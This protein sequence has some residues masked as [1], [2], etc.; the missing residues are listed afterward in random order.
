MSRTELLNP[1]LLRVDGRRPYEFRSL[2]I[3]FDPDQSSSSSSSSRPDGSIRL[4]QGLNDVTCHVFGPRETSSSGSNASN[5]VATG[6]I[7]KEGAHLDVN[8]WMESSASAGGERR[9]RGKGD[10]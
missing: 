10:R 5:A 7:G 6:G 1:S 3:H 8:V 9:V 2:E 4:I